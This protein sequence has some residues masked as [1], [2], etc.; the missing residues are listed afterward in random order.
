[1][2]GGESYQIQER[3][4]ANLPQEK[5]EVLNAY[6]KKMSPPNLSY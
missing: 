4:P 3:K 6:M 1:M 5:T 2:F